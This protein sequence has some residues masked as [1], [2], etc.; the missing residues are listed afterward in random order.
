[1][2]SSFVS[3]DYGFGWDISKEQLYIVNQRRRGKHYKDVQAAE[4]KRGNSQKKDLETSPFSIKFEYG[5]SKNGYWSYEDMVLQL[6]DCVDV[7]RA[8]NGDKYDY[9]FLFDHSNGHDGLRPDGLNLNK[10]SKYFGGKQPSMRDSVIKD[11]SYLGPY[12]H[13]NKLKVGDIQSMT[14][15]DGDNGPYYMSQSKR[16]QM[17]Y[18]KSDGHTREVNLNMDEMTVALRAIGVNSKGRRDHSVKLCRNNNL[19]L[20]KTETIVHEGWHMKPKGALQVLWERGWIDPEKSHTYYTMEGKKDIFGILDES[21]SIDSLMAKQPDFLEQETLLQYY[22]KELGVETDRSPVCHPEIAG[23]GIEFNWGCS[24]V[25]YRG[26]PIARKRSKNNFYSLVDECLGPRV[27]H[28]KQCRSNARRARSYML[29]YKVLED[30]YK[31]G[32]TQTEEKDI[33][34]S[35]TYN[36]TLIE[37]CVGLFRQRRTHCSAMDFD[38]KHCKDGVAMNI[39]TKMCKVEPKIENVNA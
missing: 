32:D 15:T 22:A 14:W 8:I 11:E 18:D 12:Q 19:P 29:A 6:E 39:V 23:E 38:L 28:I 17:K 3:R 35:A 20:K 26:Q 30:S 21:T 13:E 33:K 27:L 16:E 24:K 25:Y 36:L 37:K 7:L 34:V 1:M 2:L 31:S 5:N 10:I 9:C 4:L